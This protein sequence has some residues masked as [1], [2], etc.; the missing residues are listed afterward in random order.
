MRRTLGGANPSSMMQRTVS[1]MPAARVRSTRAWPPVGGRR[2]AVMA[3]GLPQ[4]SVHV[5]GRPQIMRGKDSARSPAHGI[6]DVHGASRGGDDA[7][8]VM[9][10]SRYPHVGV[11]L[12]AGAALDTDP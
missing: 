8:L 11:D 5:V 12:D 10:D 2:G 1:S 7:A 6:D 3:S 4:H 9:I